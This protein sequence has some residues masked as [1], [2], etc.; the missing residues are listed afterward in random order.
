MF[1][2]LGKI[3]SGARPSSFSASKLV[4]SLTVVKTVLA[5]AAA[6]SIANRG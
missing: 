5:C 2:P 1:S 4:T 3:A 6:R